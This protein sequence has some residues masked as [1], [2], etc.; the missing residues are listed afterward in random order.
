MARIYGHSYKVHET[1]EPLGTRKLKNTPYLGVELELEFRSDDIDVNNR[2]T[3]TTLEVLG[4]DFVMC[5]RD[6][7]LDNGVELVTA[8]ATL[9]IQVERW[10]RFFDTPVTGYAAYRNCGLHIHVTRNMSDLVIGKMLYFFYH[11]CD[12]NGNQ[13]P[14]AVNGPWLSSLAGRSCNEYGELCEMDMSQ[15]WN[16]LNPY[17]NGVTARM[18]SRYAALNFKS[19]HTIEFRLFAS[20]LRKERF[21][22]RL[23][24]VSAFVRW[25]RRLSDIPEE[26][27]R[28]SFVEFVGNDQLR[29]PNL[30]QWIAA[31]KRF[32]PHEDEWSENATPNNDYYD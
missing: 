4:S 25:A 14:Y 31:R 9:Q 17:A 18:C 32:V 20:T 7:S 16:N 6:G 8:P 3:D 5:K 22:R 19:N 15:R 21:L 12:A 11:N 28:E 27:T 24:F 13:L 26:W 29:Y 10:S 23:E 1:L 2:V 30:N